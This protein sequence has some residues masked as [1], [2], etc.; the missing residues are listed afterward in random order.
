MDKNQLYTEQ[1]FAIRRAQ[2]KMANQLRA[3]GI[4]DR[5]ILNVMKRIPRHRFIPVGYIPLEYGWFEY[6]YGDHA[7]PIGYGQT[8]SQ[9]YIVAYM[10]ELLEIQKGHRILEI[11]SGSG[12]Q[13]AV[14]LSLGAEVY[15]IEIVPELVQFAASTLAEQGF[16][17]FHLKEGDGY[18][19]WGE[20]SP[21]QAVIATCAPEV[22]PHELI[23]QLDDGGRM[24][25][26]VG[27][28]IQH[29]VLLIK[30]GKEVTQIDDLSV[31]FVPM[32]HRN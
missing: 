23:K 16:D 18:K 6:A 10:T 3:Y 31:R 30:K 4:K 12:Y 11:G 17:N 20:F 25:L 13:T 24:V 9:P 15:S 7:C 5:R 14:L 19:G 21:Y 27:H 29:L 22:I 8:I 28:T 26:P 1:E 2:E 32:I